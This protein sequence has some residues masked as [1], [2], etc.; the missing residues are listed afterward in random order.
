MLRPF[1]Q[2]GE[3]FAQFLDNGRMRMKKSDRLGECLGCDLRR[4]YGEVKAGH[5]TA[6]GVRQDAHRCRCREVFI[7]AEPKRIVDVENAGQAIA[8]QRFRWPGSG[9]AQA[10]LTLQARPTAGTVHVFEFQPC[11][12]KE[13]DKGDATSESRTSVSEGP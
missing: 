7:S 1:V 9:H 11:V 5:E 6:I 13:F 10:R 12:L 3:Q 4:E 8:D 2:Y